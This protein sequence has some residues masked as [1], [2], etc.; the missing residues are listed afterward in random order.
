MTPA[1][2]DYPRMMFHPTR[3][4]VIVINEA[5]EAALGP[6]WSRTVFPDAA[7]PDEENGPAAETA[8]TRPPPDEARARLARELDE[9][10][11]ENQYLR[12]KSARRRR[13]SKT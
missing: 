7:K 8:V 1:S 4:W 9:L 10:K 11:R 2:Q 5:E 3:P 6:E 13:P 12:Q